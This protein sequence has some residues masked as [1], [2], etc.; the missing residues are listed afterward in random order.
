MNRLLSFFLFCLFA[1]SLLADEY[2]FGKGVLTVNPVAHNAVRVRYTVGTAPASDLPDWIYVRH[3]QVKASDL[4]V[5]VDPSQQRLR[6]SNRA[7]RL[8]FEATAHTLAASSSTAALTITSPSDEHLYGLG[9]FQDGFADLRGLTRRLT[10]VNTQISIPVLLSSRGYG[11]L[12][13]NYGLVDF[14]P[15]DNTVALV[16]SGEGGAREVV[17]VTTTTG[18]R[19]EERVRGAF[20]GT[21]TVPEDG[22]YALVMG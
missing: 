1:G 3:D 8:V 19:R 13:N 18:G 21:L 15:A 7:G 6:I 17:N 5:E 9:Q 20:E 16:R 14:N 4:R 22:R 2:P 12:W 11:L 10:Q